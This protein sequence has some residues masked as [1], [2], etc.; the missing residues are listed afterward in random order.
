MVVEQDFTGGSVGA[1]LAV[2]AGR[3]GE[4][5]AEHDFT[6]GSAAAVDSAPVAFFSPKIFW[7][8]PMDLTR[9]NPSRQRM[10]VCGRGPGSGSQPPRGPTTAHDSPRPPARDVSRRKTQVPPKVVPCVLPIAL[11]PYFDDI[12]RRHVARAARDRGLTLTDLEK[13]L[14]S[15]ADAVKFLRECGDHAYLAYEEDA[16]ATVDHVGWIVV[17]EARAPPF[18]TGPRSRTPRR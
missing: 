14:S 13:S 6:G 5:V 18:A 1:A 17:D 4:A 15:E 8:S 11:N 7:K 2:A 16:S 10:Y 12:L 9:S 3:R